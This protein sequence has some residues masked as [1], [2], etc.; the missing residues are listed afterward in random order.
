VAFAATGVSL[1]VMAGVAV[2]GP[3][4]A[5]PAMPSPAAGPPWWLP[6]HPSGVLVTVLLW[7]AGAAGLAG[8]VTGLLAVAAGACPP[9][10]LL[11]AASLI[12][13]AVLA[14]LPPA[15]STDPLDYAAYGRMVATGHDPYLVTPAWL[16]ASGDPVGGFVP[17]KWSH[18]ASVY[19]PLASAEQGA[20]ARL[21]GTSLARITWFLKLANALAFAAT[22]GLLHLLLRAAGRGRQARAHLLWSVNPLLAW[23]L[24]A[25]GHVDAVAAAAGLAGLVL[26]GRRDGAGHPRPWLAAAAGLLLGCAAGI[27]ISYG[28]FTL[29]GLW[30]VRRSAAAVAAMVGGLLAAV[31]PPLLWAGGR[32]LPALAGRPASSTTDNVYRLLARPFGPPG[33]LALVVVAALLMVLVAAVA[34]GRLPPLCPGAPA[35]QPALVLTL[36]WLLTWPYQ[37]P[38]YDAMVFCLLALCRPARLDWPVVGRLGAAA[39]ALLPGM[40]G[41]PPAPWVGEVTAAG[42]TVALPLARAAALA[43]VL[44]LCLTGAWWPRRRPPPVSARNSAGGRAPAEPEPAGGQP[45]RAS[46]GPGRPGTG[47]PGPG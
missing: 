28:L 47:R 30:A 9:P 2:A 15:G 35:V 22:A 38:W 10:R 37:R 14:V 39:I 4:A 13:T 16:R 44:A 36:A 19:G 3:S 8:L 41:R 21:G 33:P 43:A 34:A 29:A 45:G 12:I 27:K 5:V 24:L 6:L 42:R 20:A 25:G 18:Q 17:A 23:G 31:L 7:A 1:A 46:A 32:A 40:P 11:L 26:A